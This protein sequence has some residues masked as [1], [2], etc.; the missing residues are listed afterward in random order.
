MLGPE[1]RGPPR[2][3]IPAWFSPLPSH[4]DP[5][6]PHASLQRA[7]GA[8]VTARERSGEILPPAHAAFGTNEG[9]AARVTPSY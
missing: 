8:Q 4:P 6:P 3:T 5:C 7:P 9:E 2:L 1:V